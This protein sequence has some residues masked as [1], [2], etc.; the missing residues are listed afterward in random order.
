[1]APKPSIPAVKALP[2]V[3]L[4]VL[5]G[6]ATPFDLQ[7]HRGARGLA[8]ENTLPAFARALEVGVATLELDV[9]ITR[10]GVVVVG[11]DSAPNP[12][13]ARLEGRWLDAKGPPIHELTYAELQRYDIGRLKPDTAYAKRY[14]QQVGVDGTRYARLV[15]V[16][17]LVRR[18]R[19]K[20]VRFNIE[21]KVTPQAPD[22][23]LPPEEFTRRVIAEIQNARMAD[24]VTLQSFDWRTLQVAQREAPGISTVYLSA[25]QKFL[26]TIC[27]GPDAGS[28]TIAPAKCGPSQW[29]AGQQL[30][31]QGSVPRMVKAAGGAIWSPEFRDIDED[32]VREAHAL[33]LRVVAW[34][35]NDPA[36]MER[37]LE[38]GVDGLITDRPDVGREVLRRRGL[39]LPPTVDGAT[40]LVR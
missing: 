10:D 15:D 11:H 31:E 29:T 30:R 20:H 23:T 7:G 32:K 39:P 35:V 5:G 13:I 2:V 25:Q 38:M 37:V 18:A 26:D 28:P 21:T 1:M 16:F 33:G 9:A 12:D 3:L 27:T 8:P 34:T 22:E 4:A 6:C 24:R 40:L 36:Q 17:G 19:A 14:P